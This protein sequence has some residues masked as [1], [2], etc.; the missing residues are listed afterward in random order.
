VLHHVLADGLGGLAILAALADPGIAASDARFPKFA[1]QWRELIVD[2]TR[3]KIR[4]LSGLTAGMRRG[5]AGLRELGLGT[6]RPRMVDKT[7]L[8]RPT[9]SRRR[10]ATVTVSLPD[11]VAVAHKAGGTVNDVV[12]TAVTG[13]LLATLRGRSEHPD[14]LVVSV[15]VSGRTSTTTGRLGNNIGVR[16]IA[17]PAVADDAARL[18]EIIRLTRANRHLVRASSAGPLG[19]VFRG[20]SRIGLFQSFIAHQRLVHTFETNVRG[21]AEPLCFGGH[22]VRAV[23]PAAVNPGNI[24]VSFGALSYAGVLGVTVVA[25]PDILPELNSLSDALSCVFARLLHSES[26]H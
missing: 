18:A 11:V 21:P 15:P 1:P 2:A 9:S 26:T 16:P 14:Q 23:V 4:S 24:G 8:N 3:E 5:M 17:V 12:L 7:S 22:R 20:L 25:D 19:A 10:L 13:A 6:A